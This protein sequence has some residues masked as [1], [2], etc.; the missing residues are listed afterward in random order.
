L[1]TDRQELVMPPE[2]KLEQ[3]KGFSLWMMK[4]VLN[5]Q[6]NEIVSVAKTALARWR[7]LNGSCTNVCP[8]KINIHEQI[9]AW[10]KVMSEEH[11]LPFVKSEM[12][13]VLGYVL[14]RPALYRAALGAADEA[15]RV[16]PH[17]VVANPLNTWSSKGRD[18]PDAPTQTF[19][20]WWR[21]HRGEAS[22]SPWAL[23]KIFWPVSTIIGRPESIRCRW[24]RTEVLARQEIDLTAPPHPFTQAGRS[25]FDALLQSRPNTFA[26]KL[27]V[28]DTTLFSSMAGGIGNLRRF[29]A[30][31]IEQPTRP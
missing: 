13:K 3:A 12:M 21:E 31:V 22:K 23:G 15:L 28:C 11:R 16:L 27:L 7:T 4:A 30:N 5:G 25:S 1:P 2:I 26:G 6:A 19:H 10:R 17:F 14:S 24:Y 18:M 9:L 8:V 20:A 29:W